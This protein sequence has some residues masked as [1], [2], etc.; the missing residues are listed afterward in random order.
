MKILRG[1]MNDGRCEE[2]GSLLTPYMDGR[3]NAAETRLVERHLATCL[4]CLLE[5][6]QLRLVVEGLRSL[7]RVRPN[8]SFALSAVPARVVP[9]PSP[10]NLVY[11]RRL[12][13]TLA[14]S[15][16]LLFGFRLQASGAYPGAYL[17]DRSTA[18]APAERGITDG[19]R[20]LLERQAVQAPAAT[21]AAAP[22][23]V[24]VASP[25]GAN[26]AP[27]ETSKS[28]DATA[29]APAAASAQ[30]PAPNAVPAPM[31]P[32]STPV[33]AQPPAAPAPA[34]SAASTPAPT[35]AA[36]V[37]APLAASSPGIQVPSPSPAPL[38]S[39]IVERSAAPAAAAQ[40]QLDVP[41]SK[42]AMPRTAPQSSL[43][44]FLWQGELA[45]A[46]GLLLVG[47]AALLGRQVV[48][49]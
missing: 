24:V 12:A 40:P 49:R 32:A 15:L 11:L 9:P 25:G 8:R 17:F 43:R 29:P 44:E 22:P 38:A 7:P 4:E 39:G 26:T 23:P 19:V 33:A 36:G 31:A 30:A 16:V 37:A 47:V 13:V 6:E 41:A 28:A 27:Y 42:T 14:A 2:V 48:R 1:Q 45:L 10:S 21:T 34:A 3:A 18:G 35:A 5:L 20:P 46:L